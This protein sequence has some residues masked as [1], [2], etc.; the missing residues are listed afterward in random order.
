MSKL[1][2]KTINDL[3]IDLLYPEK[4]RKHSLVY[5]TPVKVAQEALEWLNVKKDTHV[6]DIGSGIGKFCSVGA[7]CTHGQFTGV[8][9]RL[10]LIKVANS[11]N[12]KLNI[13]NVEYIHSDITEI[14]F[15]KYNSFYYY[16]PFCEQISI[17]EVIDNSIS[18]SPEKYR[19]YEDYVIE[20]FED[21]PINTKVVTYFSETFTFPDSYELKG[22][23]LEG[24]LALWIKTK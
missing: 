24:K 16:N 17:S 13:H 4:Y 14:D 12:K 7:M 6:L 11:V 9:K 15:Q 21:L 20:Q 1:N 2:S 3:E 23:K 8:E 19:E 18:F 5:W 22:L 10:D